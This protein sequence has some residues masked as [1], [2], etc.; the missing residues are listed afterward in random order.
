MSDVPHWASISDLMVLERRLENQKA[1]IEHY[2]E[3]YHHWASVQA[4]LHSVEA[5]NERA[6]E[7]LR[8][9]RERFL[10]GAENE[11]E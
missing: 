3:R 10:S 8:K 11:H 6:Q 5:Q 4:R 2:H 7:A 9:L 1:T